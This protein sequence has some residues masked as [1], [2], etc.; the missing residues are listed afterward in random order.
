VGGRGG[1]TVKEGKSL[2]QTGRE[3]VTATKDVLGKNQFTQIL[4]KGSPRPQEAK[5][6]KSRPWGE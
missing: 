1:K 3:G 2:G 4:E 5:G 6:E